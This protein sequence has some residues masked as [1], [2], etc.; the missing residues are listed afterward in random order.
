MLSIV[1]MWSCPDTA[2]LLQGIVHLI[3]TMMTMM[4]IAQVTS[5]TLW[6]WGYHGVN[7]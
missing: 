7:P 2:E 5:Y 6:G 4:D 1:R 3:Y